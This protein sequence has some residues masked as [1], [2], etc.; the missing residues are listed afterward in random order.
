MFSKGP[1]PRILREL[2][3]AVSERI[4][5][6]CARVSQRSGLQATHGVD[7]HH[8][9]RLAPG[10]DEV[11]ERQLVGHE[12]LAD[13][14]VDAFVV[15]AD[16]PEALMSGVLKG[17]RMVEHAALRRQERDG[18]TVRSC[19]HGRLDGGENGFG[20]H[21]HPAA[22]TEGNV[23]RN[24]MPVCAVVAQ[25]VDRQRD[26]SAFERAADN[27]HP[28]QAGEHLREKGEDVDLHAVSGSPLNTDAVRHDNH[29]AF[30]VHLANC[31]TGTGDQPLFGH[32]DIVRR[33]LQVTNKTN[34]IF[35]NE[36]MGLKD[37]LKT[38]GHIRLFAERLFD[39]L[40][41]QGE[42]RKR[43]EAFAECLEEIEAAKWTTMTYFTFLAFPEEHMFLKPEVTKHAAALTKA[44]LNYKSDLNWLT[45][46]CLLGF[47]KYLKDEL[48]AME[49]NPRDMIDV[50]SFM[51]CITP[52][53]YD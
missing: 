47:A 41:G 32:E 49:M 40:Y 5:R 21:H 36:K 8:G 53:K 25:I 34:L 33:A 30:E 3:Q 23:I 45:Y 17:D 2:K 44:E 7:D 4:V 52:G 46:S 28:Q 6:R 35:P 50:Q 27:A 14:F 11:T 31:L 9:R 12:V 51:W 48:V 42:F 16:Q 38:P 15:A 29:A 37:G 10:E 1:R 26:D 39:L 18:R 19:T 24:A 43:F 20:L 22:T 13:T